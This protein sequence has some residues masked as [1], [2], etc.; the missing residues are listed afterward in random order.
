MGATPVAS[1]FAFE[2]T[3]YFGRRAGV[4][5]DLSFEACNLGSTQAAAKIFRAKSN[6]EMA[7]PPPT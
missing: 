2:S 3:E 6:H 1:I 7:V 5:Y 4:R